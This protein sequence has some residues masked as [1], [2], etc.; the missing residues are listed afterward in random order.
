MD[1]H[2]LSVGPLEENCYFCI[3]PDLRGVIVDPGDEP[4]RILAEMDRLN[5]KPEAILLTHAHFD[6]VGGVQALVEALNLPVYLNPLDL[7]FYQNAANSAARFG[8]TLTTPTAPTLELKDGDF[9]DFGLGLKVIHLPGHSPGSVGFLH[10]EHLI[11]GDVLFKGSIGRYDLPGA[12]RSVLFQSLEKILLLP[13]QTY[14]Y[15]G[16]GGPTTI[17]EERRTNPYLQGK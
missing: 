2:S 13:D 15:P 10:G 8:L 5:L 14:V 1:I 17:G 16:H 6:H 3:A 12:D 9:L 11:G 4:K 7:S